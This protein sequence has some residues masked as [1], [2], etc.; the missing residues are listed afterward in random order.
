MGLG[1][2]LVCLPMVFMGWLLAAAQW[3][4]MDPITVRM[5]MSLR[6]T[7]AAVVTQKAAWNDRPTFARAVKLDPESAVGWD[8]LCSA[9]EVEKD[10]KTELANC[11][12]AVALSDN[13]SDEDVI[14]QALE[15]LG[16]PCA[17]AESY[18]KASSMGSG[19]SLYPQHM[20]EAALACG[21]LTLARSG[22]E[23]AVQNAT[24]EL[25]DEDG[26]EDDKKDTQQR[27]SEEREFLIVVYDRMKQPQLANATCKVEHPDWKRGCDCEVDKDGDVSC[28]ER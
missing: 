9:T 28:G 11:R 17:A 1:V 5:P 6:Q 10:A 13:A 25:A 20:G 2:L 26:E 21:D 3:K 14:G 22:L 15:K 23:L 16:D 7:V 12:K 18:R 4:K 8:G 24:K 27:L 19:G